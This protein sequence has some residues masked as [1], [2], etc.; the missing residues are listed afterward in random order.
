MP[1]RPIFSQIFARSP[2]SPI[3]NHMKVACAAAIKL[4][5]YIDAVLKEDWTLAKQL[6]DQIIQLEGEADDVKRD[7]RSNL[8]RSMFMPVSRSDLLALLK[9]QDKIPNRAKDIV[10]LSMGRKMEFPTELVPLMHEFVT[11]SV[12]SASMAL[13]AL[14]ELDEL[15]ESGFSRSEI[16]FI[17]DLIT[18][19]NTIEHETDVIA[20]TVQQKLYSVEKT[21]DPIDAMFL[22][23]LID[24]IGDIA[25]SAQSVG[26]KLLYLISK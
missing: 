9:S 25:D 3:Q 5:D 10:G 23:R 15:F 2:I 18:K 19:L 24:W 26:S 16:D 12:E 21:L 1:T 17:A 7:I 22:Y 6:G 20:R 14:D 13:S 11:K 4:P 8:T